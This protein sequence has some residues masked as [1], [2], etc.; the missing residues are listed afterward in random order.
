MSFWLILLNRLKMAL[1]FQRL[2]NIFYVKWLRISLFSNKL[3]LI[4][5][6][7]SKTDCDIWYTCGFIITSFCFLGFSLWNLGRTLCPLEPLLDTFL[8][9]VWFWIQIF[10]SYIDIFVLF[11]RWQ[12]F[13]IW[14]TLIKNCSVIEIPGV[15]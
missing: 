12:I 15:I 6:C 1:I 4:F 9:F 14:A 7:R 11:L 10:N 8:N 5:V 2:F 13:W 3:G